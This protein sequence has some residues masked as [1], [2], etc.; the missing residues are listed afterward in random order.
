MLDKPRGSNRIN[1]LANNKK[2]ISKLSSIRLKKNKRVRK[3]ANSQ[4]RSSR[5][6][7]SHKSSI[8]YKT[9]AEKTVE[10]T[11]SH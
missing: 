4:M 6:N 5:K 7:S 10:S 9:N 8:F 11:A 2:N 3:R 1:D